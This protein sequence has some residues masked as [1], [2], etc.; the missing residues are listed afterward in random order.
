MYLRPLANRKVNAFS[1]K[2]LLTGV[3]LAATRVNPC[4]I[5]CQPLSNKALM[6]TFASSHLV[7]IECDVFGEDTTRINE[8]RMQDA[9]FV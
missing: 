1:S 2:P 9:N 7:G 3:L 6:L 5:I 4:D 8:K